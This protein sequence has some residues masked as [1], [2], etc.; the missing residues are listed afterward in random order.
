MKIKPETEEKVKQETGVLV[1][2]PK[3]QVGETET[4]DV[5]MVV[6]KTNAPPSHSGGIRGI[7]RRHHSPPPH[8]GT[9]ENLLDPNAGDSRMVPILDLE[10][11]GFRAITI[12]GDNRGATMEL[13][14][15]GRKGRRITW[16][17]ESEKN[18]EENGQS[19]GTEEAPNDGHRHLHPVSAMVNSNV[20]TVNNS[21]MMG[22][23]CAHDSPGVHLR[24]T[25][26]PTFR[27]Y[28]GRKHPQRPPGSDGPTAHHAGS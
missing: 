20:Q 19:E 26:N 4:K 8:V 11:D 2:E 12:S 23:N 15:G 21:V 5:K 16:A 27:P 28:H 22:C 9:K 14:S 24:L 7:R 13:A 6:P 10:D 1:K 3:P 17:D 18:E 25:G